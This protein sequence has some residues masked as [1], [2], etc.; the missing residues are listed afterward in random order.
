M[1]ASDT[2]P[3][4]YLILVA[5]IDLLPQL[6]EQVVI[7]QAVQNELADRRPPDQVQQ[8]FA[9]PSEP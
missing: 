4:C 5:Q 9:Q 8:W 2:S 3:I 6:Y 1:V 7:L